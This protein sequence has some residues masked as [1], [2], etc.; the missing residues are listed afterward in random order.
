MGRFTVAANTADHVENTSTSMLI[1]AIFK[2]FGFAHR[3]SPIDHQKIT[4]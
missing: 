4:N 1:L 2:V 3:P